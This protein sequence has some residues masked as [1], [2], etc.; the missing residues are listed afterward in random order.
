MET[1]S[2]NGGPIDWARFRERYRPWAVIAG[3]SEAM[4]AAYARM[5]AEQGIHC[6]LVSRRRPALD[7]LAGQLTADHG[8]ETRVL[9]LDLA[10]ADAGERLFAACSDLEVGLYISNAGADPHASVFLDRPLEDW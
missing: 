5:L 2:T 10:E 3:A 6:V 1:E 7:A 8:I 4:G 9:A